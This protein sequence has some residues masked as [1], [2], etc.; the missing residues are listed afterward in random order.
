[1]A[2]VPFEVNG[3]FATLNADGILTPTEVNPVSISDQLAVIVPPSCW[4]RVNV[5]VAVPVTA[6]LTI[7]SLYAVFQ[8]AELSVIYEIV[9]ATDLTKP[10]PFK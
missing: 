2:I 7:E 10:V 5:F 1:M 4:L 3:E 8:L 6:A 9:P